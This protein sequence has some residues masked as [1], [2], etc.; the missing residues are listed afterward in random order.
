M[1]CFQLL[2]GV[3]QHKV[4]TCERNRESCGG[5]S[6]AVASSALSF[7]R[8][9][10]VRCPDGTRQATSLIKVPICKGNAMLL[11]LSAAEERKKT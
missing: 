10:R 4:G 9:A 8:A 6:A 7:C 11:Y 5:Q 2:V 3:V 1:R